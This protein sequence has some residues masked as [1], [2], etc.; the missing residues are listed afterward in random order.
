MS[1]ANPKGGGQDARHN[2]YGRANITR[3][4]KNGWPFEFIGFFIAQNGVNGLTQIG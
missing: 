4:S 2:L 3:P 1:E